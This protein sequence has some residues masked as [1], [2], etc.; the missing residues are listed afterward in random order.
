MRPVTL[1]DLVHIA[2]DLWEIPQTFRNDMRVPARVYASERLLSDI[3]DER[4][5]EQLVNT[6]TLPGVERHALAMPDIHQG[7]GFPIG[8][9][10]A[11]ET[12]GGVIS[13][14]GVGYDI[15]CGVRLLAGRLAVD[16]V[17]DRLADLATQMQRDVPSGVG[18]GGRLK[19]ADDEM[20]KVLN[21]GLRW[22]IENGYASEEDAEALEERGFF[23]Q[24]DASAVSHK[25]KA[26]GRDQLGTLGAGN[27]FLEIQR[28]AKVFDAERARAFGL[29][30]GQVTVLIHTGSRGLGHQVCTDYMQLMDRVMEGYQ[31]RLPDRELACA[32]FRSPEGGRYFAA[33]AAAANFAWVNRQLIT[34]A[35]RGAWARVLGAGRRTELRIVYDVAHN[36]AKLESH[37][38]VSCLVHRKGATRAFGPGHEALPER[39]RDTGQPVLIPGSMGTGSYVLAGTET[40]MRET[41]GSTCHGAGRRMSRSKAKKELD[42]N[43]LRQSLAEAGIV[44][45]A[46]SAR[47]LLEEAP[48][49]YKDVDEVV[50]VMADTGIAAKVALLRPIAI[51]KG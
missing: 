4:A 37:N 9:V 27:H 31:I 15:N 48:A 44:V 47:G 2:P 34:H 25:A 32:P 17:T 23:R 26:R 46:G 28:V 43:R 11:V 51:I 41:F 24:A 19:L 5:L 38:G 1:T 21:T 50:A 16:D 42:Y 12:E 13:P 30:E 8:G 39:Y 45:R 6:A 22:A 40:A 33:M 49:A 7:Y 18:R 35:V 3:V 36:I 10:V 29:F 20:D 14:G